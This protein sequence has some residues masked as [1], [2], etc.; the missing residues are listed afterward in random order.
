LYERDWGQR[1][2]ET[3]KMYYNF[4][5]EIDKKPPTYGGALTMFEE[6]F[7]DQ[8]NIPL[9]VIDE[10]SFKVSNTFLAFEKVGSILS[11]SIFAIRLC[12]TP[13]LFASCVCVKPNAFLI[14]FISSSSNTMYK[15][16][17]NEN[18]LK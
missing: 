4:H 3:V 6:I 14:C 2:L 8:E 11:D 9:L 16:P 18:N 13:L 5:A 15:H 17:K 12:E 1:P 7:S 10:S